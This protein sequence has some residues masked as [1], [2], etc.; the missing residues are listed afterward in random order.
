MPSL[1]N[2]P[3]TRAGILQFNENIP[4]RD[5][6]PVVNTV[7]G[8]MAIQQTLDRFEW[9]QQAGNPVSYAPLIRKQPLPGNA[10]KPVICPVRQGRPDGAQPDHQCDSCAPATWPDRATYFRND[11]AFAANP[12]VAEEP[13]H[14]PDQH[15]SAP[16]GAAIA[17]GAQTADRHLLRHAT[18]RR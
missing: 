9:V 17:V 2:L 12:A 6:P 7:P 3:P 4:L 5:Q 13:A 18:A 10:A 1:I 11:L 8:A 14:V 16:A 15:R